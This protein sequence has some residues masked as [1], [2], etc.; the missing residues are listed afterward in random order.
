[1]RTLFSGKTNESFC[2]EGLCQS[3]LMSPKFNRNDEGTV[4][5]ISQEQVV[6]KYGSVA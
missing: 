2:E 6:Q 1:M 3:D 4:P 5:W